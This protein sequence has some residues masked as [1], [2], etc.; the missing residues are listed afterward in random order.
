MFAVGEFVAVDLQLDVGLVDAVVIQPL[1]KMKDYSLRHLILM[2]QDEE[3][4]KTLKKS[5][6][7]SRESAYLN[8]D[9]AIKM[10][11]VTDDGVISHLH[12]DL[13]T[14]GSTC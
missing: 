8:I 11:N 2:C 3:I 1:K 6:E 14:L 7:D 4:S 10:S 9:L 5:Q 12:E 13:K